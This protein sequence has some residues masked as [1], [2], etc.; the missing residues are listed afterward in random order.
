MNCACSSTYIP[1]SPNIVDTSQS[2][3]ATGFRCTIQSSADRTANAPSTEKT[4]VALTSLAS[5]VGG[6]PEA[7]LRMHLGAQPLEVID[8]AVAAVLRVLVVHADVDRFFGAD[9]LA[10]AA[11][12]AAEFVDLI[13]QRIAIAGFVLARDQLDAVGGA[14]LRAYPAG[15]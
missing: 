3:E 4:V 2:A 6:I 7:R 9:F 10:V 1:A 12:D 13:D 5:G 14:D 8:E 15:H 11:E